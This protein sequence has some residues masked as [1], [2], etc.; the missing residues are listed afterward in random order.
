MQLVINKGSKEK[1]THFSHTHP[2]RKLIFVSIMIPEVG[3][4]D[5]KLIMSKVR[6]ENLITI[7][8]LCPSVELPTIQD[9][10]V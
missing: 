4:H 2:S 1:D 3:I 8:R 7:K 9:N 5:G 6:R 10:V